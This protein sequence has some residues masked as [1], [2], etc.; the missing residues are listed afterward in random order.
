M[1]VAVH[2]HLFICMCLLG[3]IRDFV[4]LQDGFLLVCVCLAVNVH[5]RI[6]VKLSTGFSHL[7]TRY[8]FLIS[9]LTAAW[10]P[11]AFLVQRF[12][13]SRLCPEVVLVFLFVVIGWA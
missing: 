6:G 3:V 12:F 1:C 4:S 9:P 8:P 10:C 5:V 11:V 2:S 13:R 7:P